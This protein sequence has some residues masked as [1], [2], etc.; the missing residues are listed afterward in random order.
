M[1]NN[2]NISALPN[3]PNKKDEQRSLNIL[4]SVATNIALDE[5]KNLKRKKSLIDKSNS[6][7][8]QRKSFTNA[9]DDTINS[10]SSDSTN[11]PTSITK[12]A[13]DNTNNNDSG[14][15][16][17]SFSKQSESKRNGKREVPSI[18]TNKKANDNNNDTSNTS[19]STS[20]SINNDQ[21]PHYPLTPIFSPVFQQQAAGFYHRQMLQFPSSTTQNIRLPSQRPSISVNTTSTPTRATA[22]PLLSPRIYQNGAKFFGPGHQPNHNQESTNGN[23]N[24]YIR[25]QSLI[26]PTSQQF[27]RRESTLR[28]A[29]NGNKA[30]TNNN[31]G[32]VNGLVS[33]SVAPLSARSQANFRPIQNSV[34]DG[35]SLGLNVSI[36]ELKSS[37]ELI[38]AYKG[39]GDIGQ[40]AHKFLEFNHKSG[41]KIWHIGSIF[42]K[43]SSFAGNLLY[44]DITPL[45]NIGLVDQKSKQEY[46]K[47]IN[48]L[49]KESK[50]DLIDSKKLFNLK[51]SIIR[52]ACDSLLRAG[53]LIEKHNNSTNSSATS[54]MPPSPDVSNIQDQIKSQSKSKTNI[55]SPLSKSIRSE[56]ED[57][58]NNIDEITLRLQKL[59]ELRTQLGKFVAQLGSKWLNDW[60]LFTV[61]SENYNTNKWSEWPSDYANREPTALLKFAKSNTSSIA[62]Y[63]FGQFLFAKQWSEI[64]KH[65]Q[66]LGI[67]LIINVNTAIDLKSTDIWVDKSLFKLDSTTF[68]PKSIIEE[69]NTPAIEWE[70]NTNRGFRFWCR[71]FYNAVT[72]SD[73][74]AIENFHIFSGTYEKSVKDSSVKYIEGPG[75]ILLETIEKSLQPLT[76][77]PS[78]LPFISLNKSNNLREI[79]ENNILRQ[80]LLLPSIKVIENGFNSETNNNNLPFNDEDLEFERKVGTSLSSIYYTSSPNN[81]KD[82]KSGILTWLK[83]KTTE[84]EKELI[85]DILGNYNDIELSKNIIRSI[86]LSK[87]EIVILKP[88]D[89]DETLTSKDYKVLNLSSIASNEIKKLSITFDRS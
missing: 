23:I 85:K 88:Q 55:T 56:S 59:N 72:Y 34:F 37:D 77:G 16:I 35:R 40:S 82:F 60:T 62:A 39:G 17:N 67:K 48:N 84:K 81:S 47:E 41:I 6:G 10:A 61:L 18:N 9:P 58:S 2:N 20:N 28:L 43:K 45:F 71:L 65:S 12:E 4:S 50:D 33:P 11:S 26:S 64:R 46:E 14:K 30:K 5:A 22:P 38:P 8:K 68:E 51:F 29:M 75:L 80:F 24:P 54:A 36:P 89:L 19:L 66:N 78:P 15:G 1:T 21:E 31:N 7:K 76:G 63:Q 83:T 69:T 32:N 42:D 52:K 87:D 57:E 13:N 86:L 27:P 49:I 74:I 44:V 79:A 25:K 70:N 53:E 73:I 3:A